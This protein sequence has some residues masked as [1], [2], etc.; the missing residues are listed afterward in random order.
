MPYS[1]ICTSCIHELTTETSECIGQIIQCPNCQEAI[2]V[3]IYNIVD[4]SERGGVANASAVVRPAHLPKS[5]EPPEKDGPPAPPNQGTLPED[6]SRGSNERVMPSGRRHTSNAS[7]AKSSPRDS[8]AFPVLNLLLGGVGL[9]LYL[10]YP[11]TGLPVILAVLA[12]LVLYVIV[13]KQN[14]PIVT[15]SAVQVGQAIW[16]S[17]PFL[18]PI[19]A[20][21]GAI[22]GGAIYDTVVLCGGLCLFSFMLGFWKPSVLRIMVALAFLGEIGLVLLFVPPLSDLRASQEIEQQIMARR[23][24]RVN[25]PFIEQDPPKSVYANQEKINFLIANLV[26]SFSAMTALVFGPMEIRRRNDLERRQ[27]RDRWFALRRHAPHD[28][29]SVRK[30]PEERD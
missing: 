17:L 8:V 14:R 25:A 19:V 11:D 12:G 20:K 4:L 21:P 28:D 3:T 27:E 22:T 9:G 26:F 16:I 30:R 10:K 18:L 13:P 7:A 6:E 15:A 1:I 2:A 5:V 29:D 24:D 23:R